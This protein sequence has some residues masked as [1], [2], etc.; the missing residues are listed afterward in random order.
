MLVVVDGVGFSIA[1]IILQLHATRKV[2][3]KSPVCHITP[4]FETQKP[5]TKASV[6]LLKLE[7][8]SGW[9]AADF[10]M[11]LPRGYAA[12]PVPEA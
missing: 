7:L 8:Y 12:G 9:L 5:L 2:K 11:T 4:G 3:E 1:L 10:A 6:H